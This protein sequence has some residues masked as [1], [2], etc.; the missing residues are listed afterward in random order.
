MKLDAVMAGY[1]RQAPEPGGEPALPSGP[2]RPMWRKL[3][4]RGLVSE[5]GGRFRRTEAGHAVP[6]AFDGS[7]APRSLAVLREVR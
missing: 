1:L 5:R 3:A 6:L 2:L 7:L 4:A